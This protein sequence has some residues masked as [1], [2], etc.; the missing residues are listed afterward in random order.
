MADPFV[1]TS[2]C[3]GT[4]D[5]AC[6]KVCPVNCFYDVPLKDLGLQEPADATPEL[7]KMLIINPDECIGCSV[8]EPECPVNAIF[9]LNAV[10]DEE[11]AFIDIN[12]NWFDGKSAEE[13]DKHRITP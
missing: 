1:V 3:I 4:R 6:M 12:K 9:D 13:L 8:C 10:P 5:T 7:K 2:K 11:T